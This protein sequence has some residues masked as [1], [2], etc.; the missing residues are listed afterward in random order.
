MAFRRLSMSSKLPRYLP[1]PTKDRDDHYSPPSGSAHTSPST[2]ITPLKPL[3]PPALYPASPSPSG[4]LPWFQIIHA[5]FLKSL[6]KLLSR[7]S[8]LLDSLP[9]FDK[10]VS[11]HIRFRRLWLISFLGLST[12]ASILLLSSIFHLHLS[13]PF[14]G[15]FSRPSSRL[16]N[17][18]EDF[19]S[20]SVLQLTD[21][22]APRPQIPFLLN[23]F[24]YPN[25]SR[26][27]N[28]ESSNETQP[29]NTR[30]NLLSEASVPSILHVIPPGKNVFSYLQWLSITSA[31]TQIA[32]TRTMAHMIAGS[33]PEPGTNFWWDEVMDL[34]GL[35]VNE[36]ADRTTIFG[37]PILDISHKTDVIRLEMLRAHGGI[38]LDTDMLVL[39]P[40]DELTTGQEEVV[41]GVEKADGTLL[42]PSL[43]NGLCN[44]VIVAKKAAKFLD[45]WYDSYRSFQGQPFRSGD[46]WSAPLIFTV[47]FIAAP[48]PDPHFF[49]LHSYSTVST[50]LT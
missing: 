38:Y 41:M 31:V 25:Q 40:F 35:E 10:P 11:S 44:A 14:F 4:S 39:R 49:P 48:F 47:N 9:S 42:R 37:N 15:L 32:P 24:G 12:I 16:L 45:V 34:P 2:F 43:V 1:L 19:R 33:V 26:L 46:T 28:F 6:H 22:G 7:L 21:S 20:P 50:S 3:T 18:E 27:Q 29:T 36:V 13:H 17:L 23:R 30:A 5:F 8:S